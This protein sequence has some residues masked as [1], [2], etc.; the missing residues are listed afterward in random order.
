MPRTLGDPFEVDAGLFVPFADNEKY[1]KHINKACS[2]V[3]LVVPNG[4]A[5]LQ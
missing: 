2:L 1:L 3:S 5:N 4:T